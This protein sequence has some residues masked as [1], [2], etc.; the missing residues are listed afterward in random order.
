MSR[1][2]VFLLAL[3]WSAVASAQILP[4]GTAPSQ[5]P[6]TRLNFPPTIA[7]A[8]LDRSYTTPIG[9]DVQ[10]VYQYVA[11]KLQLNVFVYDGGRRVTSGSENPMVTAQFTGEVDA[12]EKA[13]KADGFTNFERPAVPSACT[14]GS[15]TFRCLTYSALAQRDRL[16]SKILL[17]GYNNFFLKLRVDWSQGSGQT[18]ADAERELQIFVPALMK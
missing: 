11:N 12:A 5:H 4:G 13:M 6:G 1:F 9:R 14:Y 7:N 18:G 8:Q 3:L 15:I 10:Y 2:A 17:T 16:F